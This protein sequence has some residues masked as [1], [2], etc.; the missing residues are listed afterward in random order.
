M[1][2]LAPTDIAQE[3]YEPAEFLESLP[4]IVRYLELAME[5]GDSE[6]LGLT[7]GDCWRAYCR[8]I[9]PE[10]VADRPELAALLASEARGDLSL[11]PML[12]R[13]MKLRASFTPLDA[14][15]SAAA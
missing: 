3:T 2:P 14:T 15:A 5:D 4:A 11:L 7:L 9:R 1:K 12:L 6:E 8:N 10:A 13:A